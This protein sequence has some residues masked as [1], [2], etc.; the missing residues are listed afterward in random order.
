MKN[1]EKTP[2]TD[3]VAKKWT[4]DIMT[5][6]KLARKLELERAEMEA[7]IMMAAPLLS[8]ASCIVIDEAIHR[9][10]EIAGCRSALE[11]CPVDFLQNT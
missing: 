8:A 3:G 10:D 2:I 5:P 11:M 7:W 4:G 9:L 1:T 6:W